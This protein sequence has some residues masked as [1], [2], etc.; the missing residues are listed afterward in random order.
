MTVIE[1]PQKRVAEVVKTFGKPRKAGANHC[2]KLEGLLTRGEL[3]VSRPEA[4]T[5]LAHGV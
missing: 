1:R 5:T 4:G 2:L 3:R